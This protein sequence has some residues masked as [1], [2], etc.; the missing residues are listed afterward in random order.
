MY[1][2]RLASG[3]EETY[4][5][6]EEFAAALH[7]GT[8]TSEALIYHQRADRWLT[9]TNHP[10]YQIA[11]SRA[12]GAAKTDGSKRQV[13]SAVRPAGEVP[14]TRVAPKP[15]A[16]P[17]GRPAAEVAPRKLTIPTPRKPE[18]S[19]LRAQENVLEGVVVP[20][21]PEAPRTTVLPLR[22]GP[23]AAPVKAAVTAPEP[24][25]PDLGEG[26]DLVEDDSAKAEPKR[27]SVATPQVDKLLEMLAPEPIPAPAKPAPVVRD[28]ELLDLGAPL[29][30][31]ASSVP[32][33]VIEV[34]AQPEPVA[35]ITP[36]RSR[37]R[38]HS[39]V[40]PIAA[41]AV[42]VIGTVMFLWKPWSSKGLPEGTEIASTTLPRT[43]AFGGS[44]ASPPPA[45][46]TAE[47]SG[48]P[49]PAADSS[50]NA[51]KPNETDPAI[52]RVAAP[53]SIKVAVPTPNLLASSGGSHLSISAS[54]LIQHYN[55]AY[56]EARSELELRMLQIGFTQIF[57]K[58]R[59]GSSSGVQ[60]TRRLIASATAALRQY[61][62]DESRIERGYQDTIGV[63]GRNLGWTPRDLSVW[64]MKAGQKESAETLRLTNVML[65]Q[66]DSVF[67]LLAEQEGRFHVS[68]ESISFENS[69]ATRQY[70]ALRVWL[71][72]Q[73]D[74]YAGSGDALSATLRQVVKAIGSTRLPQERR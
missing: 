29:S 63:A 71:N 9:V 18:S 32:G 61:R 24:K 33:P 15:E 4:H 36:V 67:S 6:M 69:E 66:M 72:Q 21:R 51:A 56:T 23:S 47:I 48:T 17:V 41:A 31:V 46:T 26:L 60:D 73:A 49:A 25:V 40:V 30:K 34:L 65:G 68:G 10:H 11:L 42:L 54:E 45:P 39:K 64:N 55:V 70:G 74:K 8:V 2:I 52:V 62:N 27:P 57:L 5:S 7:S 59:L 28:V 20:P 13:I 19:A 44:S 50:R 37:S 16:S 14:P 43:D 12:P 22:S 53:R 3:A 1:R 38:K 35:A 58:S